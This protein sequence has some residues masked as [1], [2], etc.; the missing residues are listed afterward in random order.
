MLPLV[1][2]VAGL[3]LVTGVL[4]AVRHRDHT[5]VGQHVEVNLLSSALSGLVNHSSAV[6]AAGET[7][8]RMGNS[9][10]SLFPYDALPTADGELIVTAGNDRQF[11]R[12]C[13]VLGV[14]ELAD[15]P[16][17][18]RNQDRTANREELRPLLVERLRARTKD[19]WFRDII[20][21]GVPCGPINTVNDG[22]AFATELGL[23][24]VVVVGDGD[25]AAPTIRNPITFSTTPAR[26]VLPPPGLDEH[27]AEIRAWLEEKA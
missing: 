6:V 15:D 21:A 3:H 24:P 22:V 16:R 23:D 26:Y 27:G 13:E 19:E 25:A 10:P 17:F 11:R 2:I 12:L 20:A 5:G 8:T 4:A 7:P 18:L 1:D 9:H 14:P